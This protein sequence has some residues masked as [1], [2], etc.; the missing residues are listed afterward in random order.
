MTSSCFLVSVPWIPK[1]H[2]LVYTRT[3]VHGILVLYIWHN[4][5]SWIFL[6]RWFTILSM[7]NSSF[8]SLLF[9][10]LFRLLDW[11]VFLP[12]PSVCRVVSPLLLLAI[13]CWTPHLQILPFRVFHRFAV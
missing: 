6:I 9:P 4:R 2:F 10:H 1:H 12:F 5:V 8:F 13:L 11:V 3:I 7:T